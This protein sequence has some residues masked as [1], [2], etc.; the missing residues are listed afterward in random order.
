MGWD[1]KRGCG[2]RVRAGRGVTPT[3]LATWGN[4]AVQL[5]VLTLRTPNERQNAEIPEKRQSEFQLATRGRMAYRDGSCHGSNV[6]C[7]PSLESAAGIVRGC[8]Y[9]HHVRDCY[10][11]LRIANVSSVEGGLTSGSD[12]WAGAV[13]KGNM[14]PTLARRS[15]LRV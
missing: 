6:R 10:A 12:S 11:L 9:K 14:V 13:S 1:G 4:A 2:W 5:P 3:V 8:T 15:S 7:V